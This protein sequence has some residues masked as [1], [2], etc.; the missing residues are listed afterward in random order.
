MYTYERY[1]FDRYTF[2]RY[3]VLAGLPIVARVAGTVAHRKL[4]TTPTVEAAVARTVTYAAVVP[5][6]R[7]CALTGTKTVANTVTLSRSLS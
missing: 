2:E 5:N 7:G 6:E 3:L 1:T 4:Y